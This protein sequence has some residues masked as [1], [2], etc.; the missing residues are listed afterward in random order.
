MIDFRVDPLPSSGCS[1]DSHSG[2]RS[3]LSQMP[4]G[5]V[6]TIIADLRQWVPQSGRFQPVKSRFRLA[7]MCPL[8]R[9]GASRL[10]HA[11]MVDHPTW[12]RPESVRVGIYSSHRP[13]TARCD[14]ELPL[15]Q[16]GGGDATIVIVISA[17][18]S[19]PIAWSMR[20][21]RTLPN[22]LLRSEIARDFPMRPAPA[23]RGDEPGCLPALR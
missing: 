14:P 7:A 2:A 6:H 10:V 1:H 3:S 15:L 18:T 9:P 23:R 17:L 4:C 19:R 12:R 11:T 16:V 21:R 8:W 13:G 22:S 20:G 5:A